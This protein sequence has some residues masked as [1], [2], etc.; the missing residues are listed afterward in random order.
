MKVV[1]RADVDN[2]GKKGD[3]LDVADGFGRNY[4]VPKGLA[5]VATKGVAAQ[6]AAMRR[7]RDLKDARDRESA[8][9]V[10]RDLVATT[11]RVAAKAGAEGR[12]F[13]SVT[14]ADIV[15]AVQ[16]QTGVELD[17]RRLHLGEPIKSLGSHQVPV[18]LHADVE[19]LITVEVAS[20]GR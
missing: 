18:R 17:R 15:E 11:I 5:L 1:L 4:L 8:E 13:G 2:V 20:R 14:A 6:A 3:V 12:L 10:A 16:A 9:A 19:F 7:S